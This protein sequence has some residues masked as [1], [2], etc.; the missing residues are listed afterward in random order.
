MADCSCCKLSHPVADT[1]YSFCPV[2]PAQHRISQRPACNQAYRTLSC[3]RP[4]VRTL[5]MQAQDQQQQQQQQTALLKELPTEAADSIATEAPAVE[6]ALAVEASSAQST[7]SDIDAATAT[8]TATATKTE[9]E[10][11]IATEL[12]ADN[13]ESTEAAVAAVAVDDDDTAVE[14]SAML[15]NSTDD[16]EL[17]QAAAV[18]PV[19]PERK[20]RR[21]KKFYARDF[22][23]STWAVGIVWGTKRKVQT[24]QVF[25]RDDGSLVWLDGGKGSWRLNTQSRSLGFYRDFF[26]GWKGKR[27]FSTRLLDNCNEHYLEGDIKGWGPWFPLQWMGQ[28][29][30]I[31]MGV[32]L[33]KHGPAPWLEENRP[34]PTDFPDDGG[35]CVV[36]GAFKQK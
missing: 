34:P 33:D 3:S 9:P 2:A 14:S 22:A 26:L 32:D 4:Y 21:V 7:N 8:T 23:N 15:A 6:Q 5:N 31:R 11:Q 27:V 36:E 20:V 1:A 30:A 24:T 17:E 28:F 25:M 13:S 35:T 12:V 29:Q 16:T 19:V 18:A 10:E